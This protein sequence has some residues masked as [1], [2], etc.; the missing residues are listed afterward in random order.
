MRKQWAKFQKDWIKPEGDFSTKEYFQ[1]YGYAVLYFFLWLFL[2]V[3][4][5]GVYCFFGVQ[6]VF[7]KVARATDSVDS[8]VK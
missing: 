4:K 1:H 8:I 2:L 3:L 7:N 5:L 6:K